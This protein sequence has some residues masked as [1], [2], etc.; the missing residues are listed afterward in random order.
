MNNKI[1]PKTLPGFME[2]YPNEH[3]WDGLDGK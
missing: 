2:L 3:R 1:E